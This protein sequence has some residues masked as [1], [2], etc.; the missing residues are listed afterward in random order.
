MEKLEIYGIALIASL[1]LTV[2]AFFVGEYKGMYD[3]KSAAAEKLEAA[4]ERAISTYADT[5]KSRSDADAQAA[6]TTRDYIAAV[7]QGLANV[8]TRFAKLPMVVVDAHG[9]PSLTAAARLRWNA[10]E[11]LPAGPAELTTGNATGAL[12]AAAVPAAR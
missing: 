5:L 2:G 10:V 3:E 12:P 9:C 11:L 4:N 6:N 8:Q 1:L 7:E